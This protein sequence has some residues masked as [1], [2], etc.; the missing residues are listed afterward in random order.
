MLY[1]H[2]LCEFILGKLN[3]SCKIYSLVVN[4]QSFFKLNLSPGKY[5]NKL[6]S[7]DYNIF[8]SF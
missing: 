4:G 6:I 2:F 8:F 1:P 5:N 3:A 7:T